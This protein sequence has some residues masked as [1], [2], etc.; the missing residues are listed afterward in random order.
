VF[1]SLEKSAWGY[2]IPVAV[3]HRI[4]IA[5]SISFNASCPGHKSSP[6][7]ATLANVQI[8]TLVRIVNVIPRSVEKKIFFSL[9]AGYCD[10]KRNTVILCNIIKKVHSI[11][12]HP[13]SKHNVYKKLYKL[14]E[15]PGFINEN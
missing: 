1:G 11:S 4:Y 3:M 9:K 2:F 5:C 12:K 13:S 14:W 7:V 15:F 8:W 6:F 10:S